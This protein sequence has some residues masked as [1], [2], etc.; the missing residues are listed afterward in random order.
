MTLTPLNFNEFIEWD[1]LPA[2]S[3]WMDVKLVKVPC[4]DSRSKSIK[5]PTIGF[6][7]PGGAVWFAWI[8]ENLNVGQL[9]YI[10]FMRKPS[11]L[12]QSVNRRRLITRLNGTTPFKTSVLQ[13]SVLKLTDTKLRTECKIVGKIK[14]RSKG[15]RGGSRRSR[16]D[17]EGRRRIW[18]AEGAWPLSF[19][20]FG[21]I[22]MRS[23]E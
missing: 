7:T 11:V 16:A 23:K 22:R 19:G 20:V 15:P 14:S 5:Q 13:Y 18:R 9:V 21:K 3:V 4:T 12:V 1:S 10:Y 8:C 17:L 6:F 2:L